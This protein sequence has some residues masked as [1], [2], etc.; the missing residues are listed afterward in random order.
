[1][2]LEQCIFALGHCKLVKT[3]YNRQISHVIN[4][5]LIGYLLGSAHAFSLLESDVER[6]I[7]EQNNTNICS[8]CAIDKCDKEILIAQKCY[9]VL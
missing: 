9:D 1:M 4:K 7:K 5:Q 8:K 2:Y 3:L 6:T